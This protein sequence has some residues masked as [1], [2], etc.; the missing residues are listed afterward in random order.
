MHSTDKKIPT[1]DA[2]PPAGRTDGAIV[3]NKLQ[4]IKA[5]LIRLASWLAVIFRGM[6]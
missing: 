3:P 5:T 1:G 6:A 2:N 4:R